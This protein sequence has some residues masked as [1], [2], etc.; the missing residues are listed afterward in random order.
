MHEQPFFSIPSS[1]SYAMTPTTF[2]QSLANNVQNDD[3]VNSYIASLLRQQNSIESPSST[4]TS[5]GSDSGG[6]GL[7]RTSRE[8][9]APVV[10]DDNYLQPQMKKMKLDHNSIYN[11]SN[12]ISIPSIQTPA[13]VTREYIQQL[14]QSILEKHEIYGTSIHESIIYKYLS[15]QIHGLLLKD[16]QQMSTQLGLSKT[17]SKYQLAER[18]LKHKQNSI[19]PPV[20]DF[21]YYLSK[22]KYESLQH[23]DSDPIRERQVS[24]FLSQYP[25]LKESEI[26]PRNLSTLTI[27]IPMFT[28]NGEC[29]GSNL[30][31]L[32]QSTSFIKFYTSLKDIVS[33]QNSKHINDGDIILVSPG[34]HTLEEFTLANSI[35]F[36]GIDSDNSSTIIQLHENTSLYKRETGAIRFRDCHCRFHGITFIIEPSRFKVKESC[37]NVGSSILEISK[38]RF[39]TMICAI[40]ATRS[41]LIVTECKFS[42]MAECALKLNQAKTVVV[43]RNE[44][45]K[46]CVGLT[47]V[48][49]GKVRMGY[50]GDCLSTGF[51]TRNNMGVIHHAD[52]STK[53]LLLILRGNN[54]HDNEGS[55][56]TF[57]TALYPPTLQ[58]QH[59]PSIRIFSDQLTEAKAELNKDRS[60]VYIM[61]NP[62]EIWANNMVCNNAVLSGNLSSRSGGEINQIASDLQLHKYDEWNSNSNQYSVYK[63]RSTLECIANDL[64]TQYLLPPDNTLLSIVPDSM[65]FTKVTELDDCVLYHKKE[66]STTMQ[67]FAVVSKKQYLIQTKDDPFH[68][69]SRHF[70]KCDICGSDE[71]SCYDNNQSFEN[72]IQYMVRIVNP[73]MHSYQKNQDQSQN[74]WMEY[75]E[76]KICR[77]GHIII[78]VYVPTRW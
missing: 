14:R 48:F 24:I 73:A 49:S 34:I 67:A 72:Y 59:N 20:S 44:M 40:E 70:Q 23:A 55:E 30:P 29:F 19:P 1:S 22:S 25:N 41:H 39:D 5:N 62:K 69:Y 75:G 63:L 17:G 21:S 60:H 65:I 42:R 74:D 51:R 7:K 43:D 37:F 36:I 47:E 77:N 71:T 46:C 78:P 45:T 50:D 38:C 10:L 3:E 28:N 9:F 11:F 12:H 66:S 6:S 8:G 16:L 26:Y 64:K 13:I 27:H 76:I 33:N 57:V 2:N 31:T 54:I 56:V 52:E 53:D 35:E 61:N 68:N 15:S 58:E 32:F 18:I 4:T